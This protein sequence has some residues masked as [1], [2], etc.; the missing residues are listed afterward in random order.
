MSENSTN[1]EIKD[2]AANVIV[3][4]IEGGE[5]DLLTHADLSTIDKIVM[6]IHYHINRFLTK[7]TIRKLIYTGFDINFD[8]SAYS[9]VTCERPT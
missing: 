4:D 6:A 3:C 9:I 1:H 5:I 7:K 2:H 8:L